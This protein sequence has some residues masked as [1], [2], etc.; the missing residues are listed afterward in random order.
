[1]CG[2]NPPACACDVIVIGNSDIQQVAGYQL[3]V[4]SWKGPAIKSMLESC[5]PV[6]ISFRADLQIMQYIHN[7]WSILKIKKD[8]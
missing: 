6:Y 7:I 3:L 2:Y 5:P 4:A 8:L 1:M